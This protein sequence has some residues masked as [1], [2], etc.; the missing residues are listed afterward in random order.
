MLKKGYVFI[1]IINLLLLNGCATVN[2][3]DET[4][5]EFPDRV[6]S[7]VFSSSYNTVYRAAK[8]ACQDLNLKIYSE[9]ERLGRIYAYSPKRKS[10]LLLSAGTFGYGE[11]VGI[12]IVDFDEKY[13]KVDVVVQK[14]YITDLG[15]VDWRDKILKQISE[16]IKP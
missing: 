14:Q 12:Y 15:H 11:K 3:L 7:S 4:R 9:S 2:T 10:S 16:N 1:L 8:K 5:Q 13:T 6:K